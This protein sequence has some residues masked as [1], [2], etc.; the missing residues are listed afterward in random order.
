MLTRLF[1]SR[2]PSSTL[3]VALSLVSFSLG[4]LSFL[5]AAKIKQDDVGA[6]KES[7]H[8]LLCTDLSLD[9]ALFLS[10]YRRYS[11]SPRRSVTSRRCPGSFR[12]YFR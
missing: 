10:S 12:G 1:S 2:L 3:S 11:T 8:G 7:G 4:F 5:S 9:G 6:E